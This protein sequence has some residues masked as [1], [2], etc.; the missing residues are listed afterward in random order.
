M[1]LG[2]ATGGFDFASSGPLVDTL[3]QAR[4]E[5]ESHEALELRRL[6]R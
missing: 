3:N 2:G 6:Q 1:C 4:D 5:R